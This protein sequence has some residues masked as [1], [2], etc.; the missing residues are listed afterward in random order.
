V[1]TKEKQRRMSLLGI[2]A[3]LFVGG[4]AAVIVAFFAV[5]SD[6]PETIEK[7]RTIFLSPSVQYDNLYAYGDTNEGEQ[8][9]LL[10]DA[11]ESLLKDEGFTVYRNDAEGSLEDAVERSNR[12]KIGLHL[13]LHSNAAQ[14]GEV[15]GCEAFVNRDASALSRDIAALLVDEITSLGTESR[16]VKK[17]STL[18]E[19]NHAKAEA[20]V[21]LEVDF[22]DNEGGAKWLIL[23]REAIA[24]A[25]ADAIFTYYGS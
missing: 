4:I 10:A 24:Q 19:T 25:I 16:G 21:L 7:T 2:L 17:T 14:E 13:A 11:L 12:R 6:T 22:H 3:A 9:Q 8:M 18:Y 23:N 5:R 20:V 1:N 15:R